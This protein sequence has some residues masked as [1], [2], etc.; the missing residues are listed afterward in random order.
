M[1]R[2]YN[3]ILCLMNGH[4]SWGKIMNINNVLRSV[5]KQ[6]DKFIFGFSDL[7]ELEVQKITHDTESTP[8]RSPHNPWKKSGL[9][10]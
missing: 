5:I 9:T 10:Y 6:I 1:L 3:S 8:Q 7:H 4:R 2:K